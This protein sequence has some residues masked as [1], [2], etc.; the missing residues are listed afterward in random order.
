M[1]TDGDR[2]WRYGLGRY[3]GYSGPCALSMGTRTLVG[4]EDKKDTGDHA[5]PKRV[6]A[7]E[8][9]HLLTC[10]AQ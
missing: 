1:V 3:G 7:R 9:M 4:T 6:I 8:Y 5:Y 2:T 10:H